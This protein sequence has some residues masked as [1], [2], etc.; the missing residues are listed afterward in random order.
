LET[1]NPAADVMESSVRIRQAVGTDAPAIAEVLYHSFV[2]F[3]ALYTAAGFAATVL[4]AQQVSQRIDEGP[5]WV[6]LWNDQ[7]AGTASAVRQTEDSLYVR[8]IA[9]VPSARGHGLAASL[10]QEVEDFAKSSRCRRLFLTTTPFLSGA[11][12]LYERFGFTLVPDGTA[13]LFGTPLLTMTKPI[14]SK[15]RFEN[16]ERIKHVA[17]QR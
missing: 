15:K 11:I 1:G 7:I 4:D 13:D 6:A 5:V 10:L 14:A 2:E 17:E 8:G 9:V 3:Q 12:R 16:S